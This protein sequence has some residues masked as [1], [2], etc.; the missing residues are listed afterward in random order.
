[1]PENMWV[2]KPR[3]KAAI[4]LADTACLCDLTRPEDEIE[5]S[6]HAVKARGWLISI[7]SNHVASIFPSP[8]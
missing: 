1:M 4:P 6:G 8:Q 2:M 3:L 7:S 5:Q